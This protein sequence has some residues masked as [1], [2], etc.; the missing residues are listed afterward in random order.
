MTPFEPLGIHEI[1][2][3]WGVTRQR[4]AQILFEHLEDKGRKLRRVWVWNLEDVEA[5]EAQS[6]RTP[7]G[8]NAGE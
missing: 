3:R 8:R 6:G 4:A 5:Y 7:K 1:A 2:E